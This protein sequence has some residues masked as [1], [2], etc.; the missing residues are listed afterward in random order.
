MTQCSQDM[1]GFVSSNNYLDNLTQLDAMLVPKA[2]STSSQAIIKDTGISSMASKRSS[3]LVPAI[4]VKA[5]SRPVPSM[6][7]LR[8]EAIRIIKKLP[9]GNTAITL[10]AI[11]QY[12][13]MSDIRL[14]CKFKS[15]K[16]VGQKTKQEIGQS[17]LYGLQSGEFKSIFQSIEDEKIKNKSGKKKNIVQVPKVHSDSNINNT[18]KNTEVKN[19]A[20]LR[21]PAPTPTPGY[22]TPGYS[23]PGHPTPGYPTPGYP[24]P[25]YPAP[26]PTPTPVVAVGESDKWKLVDDRKYTIYFLQ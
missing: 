14:L 21:K 7:D 25:G 15:V 16:T 20:S 11:M 24:T 1:N 4:K 6:S 9:S 22:S 8:N 26:A 3:L 10:W 18:V 13:D 5:I 12:L 19:V 2:I 17:L 23:T